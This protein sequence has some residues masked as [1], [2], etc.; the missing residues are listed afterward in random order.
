MIGGKVD[1]QISFGARSQK[2]K[3]ILFGAGV[4]NGKIY[5]MPNDSYEKFYLAVKCL[6]IVVLTSLM[7]YVKFPIVQWISRAE[8]LIRVCE[9]LLLI[10]LSFQLSA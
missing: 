10:V 5:F 8:T 2:P 6:N 9:V 3:K 7:I 4:R 1:G